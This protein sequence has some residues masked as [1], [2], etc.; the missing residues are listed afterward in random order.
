MLLRVAARN[1]EGDS[2]IAT[3]STIAPRP[4]DV[5]RRVVRFM[6]ILDITLSVEGYSL[7]SRFLRS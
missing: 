6:R 2:M 1:F 3:A 5:K 7:R 4:M